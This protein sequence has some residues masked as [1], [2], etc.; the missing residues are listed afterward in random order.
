M[1]LP[2]KGERKETG[3]WKE[4]DGSR[5]ILDIRPSRMSK[6]VRK[7]CPTLG[8]ARQ[9]KTRVLSRFQ[10]GEKDLVAKKDKRRLSDLCQAWFDYHGHTITSGE[11]VLAALNRLCENLGNPI[12]A[13][14]APP[15]FLDYRKER[16]ANGVT[17]NHLN[18]ELTYLKG[19][20]NELERAGQW[21]AAKPFNLIKKL[22]MP[23][24]EVRFLSF[25]EIS[26]LLYTCSQSSN[27][28]LLPVVK[29]CL[30]TGARF[31]EANDLQ[32]QHVRNGAVHFTETKNGLN[33]TVPIKD[34]LANLLLSDRPKSGALFSNCWNVYKTALAKA[35]IDLPKGQ[36]THVLRHTF[37][38]HFMMGGGDLLV[39]NKIL[40]HQT[41]QM[42]MVYAH[43]APDHLE[44]AKTYNPLSQQVFTV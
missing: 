22:P 25:D 39:L 28:D 19:V 1:P 24:R 2:K 7:I 9:E 29:L 35:K 13:N 15:L 27:E 23:E 12:A 33:R 8:E 20:F 42:T 11:R 17:A 4:K 34:E 26:A 43:L 6:P 41:I 10:S 5:W 38:S 40:G 44:D 36:S 3:I 31:G 32:A 16:L 37:A 14:S 30:S 21:T 18:H